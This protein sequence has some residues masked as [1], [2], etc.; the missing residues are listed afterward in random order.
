MGWSGRGCRDPRV[1]FSAVVALF[2]GATVEHSGGR[3][4]ITMTVGNIVQPLW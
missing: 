3:W 2:K 4:V 1:C